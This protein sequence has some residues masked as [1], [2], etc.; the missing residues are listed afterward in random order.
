MQS[1]NAI[2]KNPRLVLVMVDHS[3]KKYREIIAVKKL[4]Q[5]LVRRN[6]LGAV[7]AQGTGRV[8]KSLDHIYHDQGGI[9]SKTNMVAL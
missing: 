8:G 2:A 9:V 7:T 3:G 6:H 1:V 5:S 4:N